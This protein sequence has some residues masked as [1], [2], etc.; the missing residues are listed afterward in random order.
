MMVRSHLVGRPHRALP[1]IEAVGG[2]EQQDHF[3]G[4]VC[5]YRRGCRHLTIFLHTEEKLGK[6]T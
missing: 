1:K 6:P 4:T 5:L 2:L 3:E